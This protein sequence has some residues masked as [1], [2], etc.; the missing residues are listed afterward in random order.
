M[1]F[2]LTPGPVARSTTVNYSMTGDA[3]RGVHFVVNGT[4]GM[5]TI[6]AGQSSVGV[7]ITSTNA[8]GTQ[9]E[10]TFTETS[11]GPN[12]VLPAGNGKKVKLTLKR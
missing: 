6:R 11:C 7:I 8:S 1:T 10:E 2:T 4:P 12:C 3:T 5:A 9:K